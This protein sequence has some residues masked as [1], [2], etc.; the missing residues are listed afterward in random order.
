M[1][2]LI[3][4]AAG[5]I[6]RKLATRIARDGAVA[7]RAVE[8]LVLADVV[9]PPAPEGGMTTDT[10]VADLAEPGVAASLAASRPDVVFHLA[11]VVSGQAEADL[12][13]GLRV[14]LDGTR[15]LLDALR[16]EGASPRVVVASSL[17]VH[18]APFRLNAAGLIPDGTQPTPLTSYGAQKLMTEILLA[19][20]TRRGILDGVSLR[21]PTIAIRPGPPNRAASSFFSN[22]LREPLHGRAA[23]LPVEEDLRHS[24]A[25][26][27]AAVAFLL[28]AAALDGAR[29]G[30]RRA[31]DLPGLSATVGEALDALERAAGPEARALV[32]REPDEAVAR[33]VR[34]WAPGFEAAEARALGFE[35][36]ASFDEIIRVYRED[37]MGVA[38]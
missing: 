20:Y 12:D 3:T 8:R 24:F 22:I 27:R 23:S 1:R 25:S 28:H 17:A 14:N 36:E 10:P 5:M 29:L 33:I 34:G 35:A 2:V 11:A 26:P 4:G 6:G 15:A 31:L 19:D 16:A 7:G 37:E 18:G 30:P 38:A 9:E 21:L 13:L 32:R